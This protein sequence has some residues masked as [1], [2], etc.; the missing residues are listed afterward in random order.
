MAAKPNIFY[1]KILL[2]L[3][4]VQRWEWGSGGQDDRNKQKKGHIAG[5]A[6]TTAAIKHIGL[7][8]G[9]KLV[10]SVRGLPDSPVPPHFF[11]SLCIL[12]RSFPTSHDPFQPHAISP[13]DDI[14]SQ[15]IAG[16]RTASHSIARLCHSGLPNM[17]GLVLYMVTCIYTFH[18]DQGSLESI[19]KDFPCVRYVVL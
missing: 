15:I 17:G 8:C 9:Q 10:T 2:E 7:L 3:L 4:V 5:K 19:S 18:A 6:S 16:G 1:T 11:Q 14:P 12:Q 13:L